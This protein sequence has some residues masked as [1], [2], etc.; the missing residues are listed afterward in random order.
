MAQV[1]WSRTQLIRLPYTR[2]LAMMT[3]DT[4][5]QIANGEITDAVIIG[6]RGM[7]V[8]TVARTAFLQDIHHRAGIIVGTIGNEY[9]HRRRHVRLLLGLRPLLR[10]T[11]RKNIDYRCLGHLNLHSVHWD[12]V[13]HG[14]AG[15]GVGTEVETEDVRK[16]TGLMRHATRT[17][18]QIVTIVHTIIGV[19]SPAIPCVGLT[20]IEG[21]EETTATTAVIVNVHEEGT[22]TA[23]PGRLAL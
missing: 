18:I 13:K 21:V 4:G 16:M 11:T 6:D 23:L 20:G 3:G 12:E 15:A 7:V 10:Q 17:P 22:T 5:T 19:E 2:G 14:T 8:E 1:K 9:D